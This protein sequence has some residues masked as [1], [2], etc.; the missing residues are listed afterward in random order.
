MFDAEVTG[1]LCFR[2][3]AD[4]FPFDKFPT[5]APKLLLLND[6]EPN[7]Q[8]P[9]V[10][11]NVLER[12]PNFP[13]PQKGGSSVLMASEPHWNPV[14]II[15][16]NDPFSKISSSPGWDASVDFSTIFDKDEGRLFCSIYWE[17]PLPSWLKLWSGFLDT[18]GPQNRGPHR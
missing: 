11:R 1:L 7:G 13:L 3:R 12:C 4:S 2:P 15:T 6:W 17:V 5:P 8:Q 14:S 9:Q 10:L 16:A 18:S